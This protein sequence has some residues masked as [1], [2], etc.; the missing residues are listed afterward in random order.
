[1]R[2]RG[3]P[4][5]ARLG[6]DAVEARVVEEVERA[7]EEGETLRVEEQSAAVVERG[8]RRHPCLAAGARVDA[9]DTL[10]RAPHPVRSYAPQA[11]S[12][13]RRYH[14]GDDRAPSETP[15]LGVRTVEAPERDGA[16]AADQLR[17]DRVCVRGDP[18]RSAALT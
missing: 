12:A 1:M 8:N 4:R 7:A 18:E 14:G 11:A 17:P 15:C 3:A 2:T 6:P 5:A 13:I 10:R 16:R 9:H